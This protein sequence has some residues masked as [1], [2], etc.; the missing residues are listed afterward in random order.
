MMYN[1]K[2]YGYPKQSTTTIGGVEFKHKGQPSTLLGVVQAVNHKE[3][4]R[5]A[6]ETYSHHKVTNV[7]LE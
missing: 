4:V 7:Y 3:A 5:M 6:K 1:W 2:V